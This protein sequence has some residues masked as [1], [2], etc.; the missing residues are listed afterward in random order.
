M[1]AYDDAGR[2]SLEIIAE[3]QRG[4]A[5]T[6][7]DLVKWRREVDRGAI[8]QEERQKTTDERLDALQKSVDGLRRVILGFAIS[9]AGSSVVFALSV[10]ISTGKIG[11]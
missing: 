10:L 5:R 1:S 7:G 2:P 11:G 3:R 9:I 4:M 8:L 6:L